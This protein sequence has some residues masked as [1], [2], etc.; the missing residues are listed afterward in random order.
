LNYAISINS[1]SNFFE[2]GGEDMKVLVVEPYPNLRQVIV[3]NILEEF[4][5]CEVFVADDI[6]SAWQQV[7]EELPEVVASCIHTNEDLTGIDLLDLVHDQH[8]FIKVV[9]FSNSI[10]IDYKAD[11]LMEKGAYAAIPKSC[12]ITEHLNSAFKSM[13]F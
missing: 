7:N 1:S 13:S 8:P 2:K 5:K 11:E 3:A 12:S 6:E 9:L 4:P 10:G